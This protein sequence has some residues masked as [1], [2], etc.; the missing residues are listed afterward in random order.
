[1]DNVELMRF[2]KALSACLEKQKTLIDE[3]QAVIRDFSVKL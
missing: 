3:I 2:L 1:L